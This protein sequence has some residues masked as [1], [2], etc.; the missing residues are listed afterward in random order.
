MKQP[1]EASIIQKKDN[2]S[3]YIYNDDAHNCKR[4]CE[5]VH[6]LDSFI[7]L[8]CICMTIEPISS[9]YAC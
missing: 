3:Q 9:H 4:H 7:R 2:K 5:G 1:K 6:F 8:D